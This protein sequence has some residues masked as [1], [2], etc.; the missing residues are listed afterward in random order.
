MF[1]INHSSRTC[2]GVSRRGLLQV[3]GLGL[4]GLS[5]PQLLRAEQKT[6]PASSDISFILLWTNGGLSN[7]QQ[8]HAAREDGW[9]LFCSS[10][11]PEWY[12]WSNFN[13]STDDRR[14]V[15]GFSI[16]ALSGCGPNLGARNDG[17]CD[18]TD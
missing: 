17:M 16:D 12:V 18:G 3:G 7:R 2:E 15:A 8:G 10:E 9:R 4:F 5:L 1:Q 13:L 6:S 14:G 11:R